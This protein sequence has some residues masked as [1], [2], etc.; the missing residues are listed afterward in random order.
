V[1]SDENE[2][3]FWLLKKAALRLPTNRNSVK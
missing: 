2:S 1:K 3:Y